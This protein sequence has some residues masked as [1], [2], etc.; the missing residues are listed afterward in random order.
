MKTLVFAVVLALAPGTVRAQTG[1]PPT[2]VRMRIGPLYVNPTM[3]LSNAGRDTN[4]FNDAKNPQQDFTVTISP[5]TDLWLRVGPSWLQGTIKEDI[6]WFQKF[7][8]ERS[9]NNSY[10]LKWLVPLNR[11]T[12]APAWSYVNTRE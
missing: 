11:I 4:V 8:S 2:N 1:A 9:A 6:V 5:G 10:A 3:S 7:A 12:L